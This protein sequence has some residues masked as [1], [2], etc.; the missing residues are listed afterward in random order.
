MLANDSNEG[1]K[2]SAFFLVI[3]PEHGVA[4]FMAECQ[5]CGAITSFALEL[6]WRLGNVTC[7]ECSTSMQLSEDDILEMRSQLREAGSRIDRLADDQL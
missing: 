7:S 1:K 2:P 6:A 4:E 5:K 3:R